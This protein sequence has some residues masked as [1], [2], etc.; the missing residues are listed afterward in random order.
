MLKFAI[1]IPREIKIQ[2]NTDKKRVMSSKDKNQSSQTRETWFGTGKDDANIQA[3]FYT[4]CL[5]QAKFMA[6]NC[7][8][9]A[10]EVEEIVGEVMFELSKMM[11]NFNYDS[12]QSFHGLLKTIVVRKVSDKIYRIKGKRPKSLEDYDYLEDSQPTNPHEE[13]SVLNRL[14]EIDEF[15]EDKVSE[16]ISEINNSLNLAEIEALQWTAILK[17]SLR[18]DPTMFKDFQEVVLRGTKVKDLVEKKIKKSK[19]DTPEERRKT[20]NLI[21]KH[22]ERVQDKINNEFESLKKK[23]KSKETSS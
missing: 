13:F 19:N 16:I 5:S 15:T 8:L 10:D 11:P 7:R 12:S 9:N 23:S 17:V 6:I 2:Q 22:K 14:E 18:E 20:R 21:Y 1:K 4:H 3:E